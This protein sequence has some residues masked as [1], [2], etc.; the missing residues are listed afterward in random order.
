MRTHFDLIANSNDFEHTVQ[1]AA[2]RLK[3]PGVM[4]QIEALNALSKLHGLDAFNAGRVRS[5]CV[6][7]TD[8]SSAEWLLEATTPVKEEEEVIATAFWPRY[9]LSVAIHNIK[10]HPVSILDEANYP[11][12]AR[13]QYIATCNGIRERYAIG[14][15]S[16][17]VV[18]SMKLIQAMYPSSLY[19]TAKYRATTSVRD[20]YGIVPEEK[21]P[22]REHCLL[23]AADLNNGFRMIAVSILKELVK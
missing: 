3:Y 15:W 21:R 9:I 14:T 13:D 11:W 8:E 1:F 20:A 6:I 7:S 10:Q 5:N 12:I 4:S 22:V 18:Q 2:S 16:M 23:V 17:A 19:P